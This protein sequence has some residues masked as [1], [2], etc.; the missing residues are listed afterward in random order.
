MKKHVTQSFARLD[1]LP[2]ALISS[3]FLTASKHLTYLPK[4]WDRVTVHRKCQKVASYQLLGHKVY[5]IMRVFTKGW[6]VDRPWDERC[7]HKL[8]TGKYHPQIPTVKEHRGSLEMLMARGSGMSWETG[9][10]YLKGSV[11]DLSVN[12][13]NNRRAG[14]RFHAVVILTAVAVGTDSN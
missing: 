12:H 13:K 6:E 11:P 3:P 14:Y 5:S 10:E 8:S 9:R 1:S 7:V 4:D 2:T